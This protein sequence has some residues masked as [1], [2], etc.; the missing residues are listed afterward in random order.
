[1]SAL[2][3]SSPATSEQGFADGEDGTRIAYEVWSPPD[4]KTPLETLVLSD[5]IGCDGYIWK[6]LVRHFAPDYRIVHWQFRGHGKSALPHDRSH[7]SFDDLCGDL[8]AVLRATKTTRCILVGHSMGVQICLEYQRR[9]PEIARALILMCGGHGMPLD[10]FHE[11]KILKTAMPIALAAAE[12]FPA[13]MEAVWRT[14]T[15]SEI[16]Y[17]ISMHTEVN[18]RLMSRADF[19]PY[20]E[21]LSGMDPQLFFSMLL[22]AG[23]HSAYEHLPDVKPPVLIV[24]GTKDGFTPFWLSEEM[25]DRIPRAELLTV[26]GGTHAAPLEQPELI[27]LRMEKFFAE[28]KPD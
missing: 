21:H 18:G 5:G 20:F 26:P 2:I 23:A 8:A 22:H 12:K 13:L 16:S 28:L 7:T 14:L 11:S 3:N 27:E 1:M 25:H 15:S 9:H 24:A 10:T 17:Q 6:Y 4:E 19:H